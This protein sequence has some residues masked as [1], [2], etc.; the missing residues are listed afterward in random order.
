MWNRD[1][2]ARTRLGL[3]H[4]STVLCF[5]TNSS[6][7]FPKILVQLGE[8]DDVADLEHLA[9]GEEGAG[10]RVKHLAAVHLRIV[11]RGLLALIPQLLGAMI[12]HI[13]C[14]EFDGRL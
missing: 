8:R 6:R 9:A 1:L 3:L 12:H 10:L 5:L 2:G 13:T 14:V 11:R 4:G 7:S